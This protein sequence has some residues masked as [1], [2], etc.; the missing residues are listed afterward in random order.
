MK[1]FLNAKKAF[2]A[3]LIFAAACVLPQAEVFRIRKTVR[4]QVPRQGSSESQKCGINDCV[5]AFLPEDLTFIQGVELTVKI[6]QSIAAYRNTIIYSLYNNIS[7][8][9]SEKNIDYSGVEIYSGLYPGQLA[10][11]I[12]I[13]ITRGNTIK[14]SPYADKTLAADASRGFV[15]I[16]NQLAMKGV[17]KS[18]MEAE[19]EVSAKAVLSDYGALK[20]SAPADSG[21]YSVIVDDKAVQANDKGLILLKPGKR[22]VSIVSE[23]FRN[24]TRSVMVAQG[25]VTDLKLDLQSVEPSVR[26][27]AP[28]GTKVFADGNEVDAG[29]PLSL[30]AGEHIFKFNLG[31]YEVTKKVTIQNGKS[32]NIS[33]NVDASVKEE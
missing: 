1:M 9:P 16:R 15:F 27:S 23:K 4:I 26:V 14:Q 18:V 31:G 25:E 21:E 30:E 6:P 24:E 10:W 32:Y 11:S 22:A 5:A 12:V 29:A 33:V 17:P 2:L 13:P 28:E 3:S 20:I 19:F 8:V 7:P